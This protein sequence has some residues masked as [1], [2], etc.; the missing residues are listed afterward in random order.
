MSDT[1]DCAASVQKRIPRGRKMSGRFVRCEHD[2]L[3][4]MDV[5]IDGSYRRRRECSH[6][7]VPKKRRQSRSRTPSSVTRAATRRRS[8]SSSFQHPRTA[9]S[10]A[11]AKAKAAMAEF[12]AKKAAARKAR[13]AGGAKAPSTPTKAVTQT[14]KHKARYET[15]KKKKKKAT[16][17]KTPIPSKEGGG[18]FAKKLDFH[19]KHES[20][21][22]DDHEWKADLASEDE[23]IVFDLGG[24]GDHATDGFRVPAPPA[25]KKLAPMKDSAPSSGRSTPMNAD[26]ARNS[27]RRRRLA[28]GTWSLRRDGEMFSEDD[29]YDSDVERDDYPKRM[30]R[31]VGRDKFGDVWTYSR[32][33]RRKTPSKKKSALS[34]SDEND[35]KEEELVASEPERLHDPNLAYF[36]GLS[37]HPCLPY[38]PTTRIGVPKELVYDET[39]DVP[40]RLD[41]MTDDQAKESWGLVFGQD[42]QPSDRILDLSAIIGAKPGKREA[43]GTPTTGTVAVYSPLNLEEIYANRCPT[44]GETTKSTASDATLARFRRF[45]GDD[46]EDFEEVASASSWSP[47][48]FFGSMASWAGSWLKSTHE[49]QTPVAAAA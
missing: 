43:A 19:A 25:R 3:V 37:R 26:G 15:P 21:Y 42:Y 8:T 17:A 7:P 22:F 13:A 16:V 5:L 12:R 31:R 24:A 23:S 11:M 29:E 48:G 41:A 4:S 2:R 49:A 10:K 34:A 27:K 35:F 28:D 14:A 18:R 30:R 45:F 9:K 6:S 32:K 36:D 1:A 40:G 39:G 46:E 47:L 33:R 44:T 38:E 20:N